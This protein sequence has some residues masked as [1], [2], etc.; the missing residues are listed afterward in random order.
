MNFINSWVEGIIVAV[1]VATVIE[2]ILPNGNSKKYIKIVIGVYVIFNIVSPIIS[3]VTGSEFTIESITNISKYEQEIERYQIDSKKVDN[4]NEANIKEIYILNLKKDIKAKIEAKGYIVNSVYV[5]VNDDS[6]YS[7]KNIEIVAHKK[8]NKE[9]E[10]IQ[11]K[12]NAVN[13]IERVNI[14]VNINNNENKQNETKKE[15]KA[16]TENEIKEIKTYIGSTYEIDEKNIKV[17]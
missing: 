6:E 13:E 14:E 16:L 5:N 17:N 10:E 3:K 11:D 2:M 9:K 7:I 12:S 8:E 15:Y 4:N 1:V